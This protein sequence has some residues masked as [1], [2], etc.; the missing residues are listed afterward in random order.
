MPHS[1]PWPWLAWVVGAVAG[2]VHR[3][4]HVG[5]GAPPG[6]ALL[7]RNSLLAV[8]QICVDS[9]QSARARMTVAALPPVW[10]AAGA[11][12]HVCCAFVAAGLTCESV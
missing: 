5:P 12:W 4:A 8:V 11:S 1:V 6:A 10:C 9:A 2:T 3:V 7:L